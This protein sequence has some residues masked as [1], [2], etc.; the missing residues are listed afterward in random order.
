M[1]KKEIEEVFI[2]N[3]EYNVRLKPAG[4]KDAVGYPTFID[5]KAGPFS[6]TL[7]IMVDD[8]VYSRLSQQLVILYDG[9]C[10]S[11]YMGNPHDNIYLEFSGN[12]LGHVLVN[13][14]VISRYAPLV[15][16]IFELEIDQTYLPGI[17]TSIDE[18]F[19]D[20]RPVHIS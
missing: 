4:I 3:G 5:V 6:G 19:G 17:I 2:G 20:N 14:E 13:V 10:G 16:L 1:V 9:L 8:G 18:L 12:G 7:Q 15:K 11:A